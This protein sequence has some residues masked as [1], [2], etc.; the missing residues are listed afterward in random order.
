MPVES[1]RLVLMKVYVS[2]ELL[3]LI[4]ARAKQDDRPVSAW[5]R[6]LVAERLAQGR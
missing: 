6:R 4:T 3:Q 1:E 2:A 5:V